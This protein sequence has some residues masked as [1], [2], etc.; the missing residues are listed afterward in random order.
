MSE[1][2]N[3]SNNFLLEIKNN[4]ILK[5]IFSNLKE[6]K[7]LKM[8]IY[9]NQLQKRVNKD[10]NDYIN[11]YSKI[12]I[13]IYPYPYGNINFINLFGGASYA[14]IYFDDNEKE[15]KR[16]YLNPGEKVTKIKVILDYRF[17]TLCGLFKECHNIRKISFIKFNRDNIN[18]MSFMFS[19]CYYLEELDLSHFNTDNV[20]DMQKMFK[21][22]ERLKELNLSNF[23]TK[24]VKN[25]SHIFEKCK[26]LEKLNLLNFNI[27]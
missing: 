16:T 1:P 21:S 14:H 18:N 27:R 10:I 26:S 6:S 20:K 4:S 2:D 22:C 23:D 9:N 25:M 13:E 7:F 11:E 24:K 17:K 8:I 19:E 15:I 3:N 12:V 5:R